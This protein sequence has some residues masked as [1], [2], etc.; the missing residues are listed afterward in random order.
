MDIGTSRAVALDDTALVRTGIFKGWTQP[1]A[2][3]I[4]AYQIFALF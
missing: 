4:S 2:Y 3:F 1:E